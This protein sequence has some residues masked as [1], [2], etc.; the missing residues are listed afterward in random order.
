MDKS[1]LQQI[2]GRVVKEPYTKDTSKGEVTEFKI[3]QQLEYGKGQGDYGR[4]RLVTVTV[5]NEA[6]QAAIADGTDIYKGATVAVEGVMKKADDQ[7]G[8][9]SAFRVGPTAWIAK[10]GSKAAAKAKPAPDDDF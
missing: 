4:S 8:D 10:A 7:Y 6:L 9:F 2:A 3:S 5:W 1:D